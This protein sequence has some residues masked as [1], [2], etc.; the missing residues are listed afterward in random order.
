MVAANE[1]P[2]EGWTV[3]SRPT[4]GALS[5]QVTKGSLRHKVY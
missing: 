4:N 2:Q 1:I 3:G 5:L